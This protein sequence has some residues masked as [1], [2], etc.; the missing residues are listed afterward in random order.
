MINPAA[1]TDYKASE[2]KLQ[3]TILWWI[4]A[5]GKNGTLTS[6]YLD[7]MLSEMEPSRTE[8]PFRVLR[9][10]TRETIAHML[11]RHGIGCYNNKSRSIY[12]LVHSGIDLKTCTAEELENIYGI[13]MKTSR[14]FIIHSREGAQ[15][16]GLDTHILKFL[17]S[18]GISVPKATPS[19]KEQY[20]KLEKE[21][22]KLAQEAGKSPAALDLEVW[23][24]Y[25]VKVKTNQGG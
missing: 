23:N 13:G 19:S 25:S 4:C 9:R 3:E 5:A 8:E 1:I 22:L 10:L 20:L 18:R 17:G 16:A 11:K 24:A 7:N 12:E 2:Y 6:I 21:F 14:C 15:Y